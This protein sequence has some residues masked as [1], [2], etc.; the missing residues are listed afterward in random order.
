VSFLPSA[1]FAGLLLL[2]A[3]GLLVW[4]VRAWR[5]QRRRNLEPEE[6]EFFRRQFRRRVQ[7]STLLA[8]VAASLPL[9][10]WILQMAGELRDADW[11]KRAISVWVVVVALLLAWVALLALADL[12]SSRLYFSRVRQRYWLEKTRLEAEL[13]RI[14]GTGGNGKPSGDSRRKGPET[15]DQ[16]P[17]P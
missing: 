12:W 9:G 2:C 3:A 17:G 6:R 13:R 7:T 16:G 11:P 14:Q 10:Q 4:H 1:A 8:V 5:A 15:K